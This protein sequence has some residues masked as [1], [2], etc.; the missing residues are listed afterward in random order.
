MDSGSSHSFIN[1]QLAKHF[2]PWKP[3]PHSVQVQVAN[4]EKLDCTHQLVDQIW[5]NQGHSFKTT[6]K[7]L[8]LGSYDTILGMGWLSSHSPWKFTGMTGG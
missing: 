2:S 1:D 8:S 5:G 4:G 7:I 6:F 3:L